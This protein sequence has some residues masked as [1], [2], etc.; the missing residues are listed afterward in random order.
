MTLVM[1]FLLKDQP[2][3]IGDSALSRRI[4]F[5]ESIAYP[6]IGGIVSN[7]VIIDGYRL[8]GNAQKLICPFANL[9]LGWSGAFESIA[10]YFSDFKKCCD[11]SLTLSP[12]EFDEF[13]RDICGKVDCDMIGFYV[14]PDTSLIHRWNVGKDVMPISGS[15]FKDNDIHDLTIIGSGSGVFYNE[16]MEQELLPKNNRGASPLGEAIGTACKLINLMI[17]RE[18]KCANSLYHGYGGSYEIVYFDGNT[19]RKFRDFFHISWVYDPAKPSSLSFSLLLKP[20]GAVRGY[21]LWFRLPATPSASSPNLFIIRSPITNGGSTAPDDVCDEARRRFYQGININARVAL[22]S[23]HIMQDDKIIDRAATFLTF[24]G[25]DT[26]PQFE[27]GDKQFTFTLNQ[28]LLSAI[29]EVSKIV[30]TS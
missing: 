1:S 24:A 9:A 16:H 15:D 8:A 29:Q 21:E 22:H 30:R 5:D 19:F 20:L 27:V 3:L 23:L 12:T 4:N 13:L 7:N 26:H 11:G 28:Y 25:D 14:N 6:T 17:S 2:I 10:R 18:L